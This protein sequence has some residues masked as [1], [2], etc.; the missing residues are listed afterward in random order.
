MRAAITRTFESLRQY[1]VSH[2]YKD[3]PVL[4]AYVNVDPVNPDNRRERPAWMI[5][6][7]N[8]L[9]QVA[10]TDGG[11]FA[12][13]VGS[14]LRLADVE[15]QVIAKLQV[16]VPTGRSVVMFTDFDDDIVVDLPLPVDT[17]V[18]LGLPQLKHLLSHLH[19]F[20]KYLVVLFSETEHRVIEVDV[21]GTGR[22]LLASTGLSAGVALR[23]G[24]RLA[25]TQASE[26]RDLDTERGVV[27]EAA[28]EINS[29]F[30]GDPEFDRMVFGG[31][32]K[33][34][35]AVKNALHHTVAE[36][37]VS[38][39]PIPLNASDDRIREVVLQV[40]EEHE[41]SSD[42]AAVNDLLSRQRASGRAVTGVED[43]MKALANGQVRKLL[44][45]FPIE[46]ET[47]DAL[48]VESVLANVDV[49]LVHG[50]A[51]DEL[52]SVGGVGAVLY[53]AIDEAP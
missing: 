8:E 51:A 16:R 42:L 36:L 19:R 52:N 13:P 48:L 35:S 41:E 28:D 40:A 38:V 29:Y 44:I 18:Y 12:G 43:V 37:L 2:D 4:S 24:G 1:L 21:P 3:A 23:P 7:K 50:A 53:Y 17:R 49:E 11:D 10:E 47:F 34:A 6:L 9:R 46:S 32:L 25:R 26:R 31:N 14:D 45:P 30:M 15:E 22:E 39:E 20:G 5:E 27:R 33:L